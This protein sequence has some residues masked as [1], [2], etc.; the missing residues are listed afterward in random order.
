V[1]RRMTAPAG[2]GVQRAT[3]DLRYT[4]PAI[5]TQPAGAGG[6]EGGEGGR[7]G[8]PQGSPVMP[9]KYTVTMALRVNGV[10]TPVAGSQSFNVNVEGRERMTPDDLRVLG[11]FQRN[12]GSL[13]RSVGAA[14]ASAAEAKSRI[15]L[16]RRSA[17]EAPVENTRLI[18]ESERLDDEIDS[19]INSLRGGREDSDI[20]PPSLNDRVR[21]I[22]ERIR[23]SSL[24]PTRTQLEQYDLANSEFQPVLARLRKLVDLDMPALEKA[25]ADAGA[26]LIQGQLPI[27]A[28]PADEDR[29]G[30][31]GM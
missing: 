1:V 20:P 27:V 24:R 15:G 29:P 16:L 30:G 17:Q 14:I 19:I 2:A 5:R 22:A 26:P 4:P 18:A 7:F 25:L 3:W 12:V 9:G 11:E 13:E 31:A 28:N 10:V 21:Y 6:G 8:A 23:L